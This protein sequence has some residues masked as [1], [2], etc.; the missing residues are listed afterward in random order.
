MRFQRRGVAAEADGADGA[1]DLA[2]AEAAMAV[3]AGADVGDAAIDAG[4]APIGR[5]DAESASGRL[6]HVATTRASRSP[7]TGAVI[8][9]TVFMPFMAFIG[10]K[11]PAGFGAAPPPWASC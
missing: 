4:T 5:A 3:A 6:S 10:A 1:G 8:G 2:V 9:R 7:P 11:P